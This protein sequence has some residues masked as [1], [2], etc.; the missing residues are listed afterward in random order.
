[1]ESLKVWAK[2]VYLLAVI[3]S[4][5]LLMIPRGMQKQ[6]RFVIEML[7]LLCILAPVAG[8]SG[9]F[10]D[11]ATVTWNYGEYDFGAASL[12]SFYSREIERRVMEMSIA[13]GLALDSVSV[14]VEGF[15]PNFQGSELILYL[16]SPADEIEQDKLDNF[17]KLLA[18]H[19]S[20]SI[21]NITCKYSQDGN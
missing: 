12:E 18:A 21:D 13:A 2:T 9:K 10:Y 14:Q 1:M 15:A 3:S 16:S 17:C 7:M 5:A 20:M 11:T 6:S 8:F 19:L 4:A